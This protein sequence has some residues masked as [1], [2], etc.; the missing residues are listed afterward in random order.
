V[1]KVPLLGDIP[2]LGQIFRHKT[3]T[4][5]KKNLMVFIK[6]IIINNKSDAETESMKSYDYIRYQQM[7]KQNG[8][9][10]ANPNPVLPYRPTENPANLPE[11]FDTGGD[12]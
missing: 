4:V 12:K 2:G 5:E 1:Q 11:P 3:H 9:G 8:M 6:P 7:R 10:L